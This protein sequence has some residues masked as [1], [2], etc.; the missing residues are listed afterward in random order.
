[1]ARTLIIVV[2]LALVGGGILY[3]NVATQQARQEVQDALYE[4]RRTFSDKA[5]SIIGEEDAEYLDRIKAA[6]AEYAKEIDAVYAD[7]PEWMNVDAYAERVEAQFEEGEIKEAQKKSMLEGFE[8]VK[9]GYQ[10][11]LAG[12]WKPVLTRATEDDAVRMD[13]YAV[14]RTQDFDGNPILEAKAFLWGVEDNTRV[15]WGQLSLR[16]WTMG[17]P[18]TKKIA[19]E[20]RRQGKNAD[21]IEL[22]LGRAEGDAQPYVMLQ[23]P[24]NY[25]ETFPPYVAIAVIRWPAMPR[26]AHAV[27]FTYSFTAK[28]GGSAH[29]AEF[30]WEKMPIPPQWQLGDDEL[31]NADVVEATEEEIVPEEEKKKEEGS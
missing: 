25:I 8:F 1:M 7:H 15:N 19:R 21:E 3:N 24:N 29:E 9:D 26:E 13:I 23:N 5:A 18:P 28:K 2:L 20:L 4:T 11:L 16:Y 30:A 12:N 10:T 6:L 22:V 17:E 27:D 31:W 14:D